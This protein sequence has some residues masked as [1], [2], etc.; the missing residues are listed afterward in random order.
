MACRAV[1]PDGTPC[2]A[3]DEYVSTET[4]LCWA[5]AAPGSTALVPAGE[6]ALV[7]VDPTLPAFDET[8]PWRC[9]EWLQAFIK[10]RYIGQAAAMVG[11]D[12]GAHRHWKKTVP[13]FEEA[14]EIALQDVRD[15][16]F[17]LLGQD[18][19][20]GGGLKEVM[21]DGDGGLKYT[22]YRQSEGLRKMRLMA[23]DPD[24]YNPAKSTDSGVT[25]ILQSVKEGGW[26]NEEDQQPREILRS[27]EGKLTYPDGKG[28]R[29]STRTAKAK[30]LG[31]VAETEVVEVIETGTSSEEAPGV[32]E[33]A[34]VIDEE[35]VEEHHRRGR[36]R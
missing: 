17:D 32:T 27:Q 13:G 20:P 10:T 7:V 23:L 18:N 29:S 11:V 12:R 14:F 24:R 34:S 31:S 2:N 16:E 3:P 19:E 5:C 9:V 6:T 4:G 28:G 26:G 8:L 25:I 21:Y 33:Q 30:E 15:Q 36:R 22:R 1:Q 35:P